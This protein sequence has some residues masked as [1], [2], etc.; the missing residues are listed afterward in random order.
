MQGQLSK[1]LFPVG[2]LIKGDVRKIAKE[3][4]LV[5]ANKPE[6]MGICFVGE[7]DVN[8]FLKKRIKPKQGKVILKSTSEVIGTH[9]GIWFYTIGQRHGF[10]IK[11]YLGLPL[12]VVGKNVE[13]NELIVGF[14]NDCLREKFQ[15]SD[16][17]VINESRKGDK[18][19]CDV[20]IR[21]LGQLYKAQ[22]TPSTK[23]FYTVDLEQQAFGIAPGQSA[24]FYQDDKVL[25][26]GI[27]Q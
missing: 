14:Y 6:S 8:K 5:V 2:G 17:H 16:V 9:E 13:R 4:K 12:Y 7:V 25:G 26:G 22:V 11:K 18:F 19:D 23:D 21:H 15:V 24:V 10:E 1:S 20:R 3:Q 27:I